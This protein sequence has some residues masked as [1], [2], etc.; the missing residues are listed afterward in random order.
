MGQR[1]SRRQCQGGAGA[2][3]DKVPRG[4]EGA[5]VAVLQCHEMRAD[6]HLLAKAGEAVSTWKAR[7]R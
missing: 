1:A 4:G 3:E 6:A 5:L 2:G 7:R